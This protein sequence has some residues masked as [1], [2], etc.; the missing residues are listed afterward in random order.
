MEFLSCAGLVVL[1]VLFMYTYQVLSS[2]LAHV[3]GPWYNSWT[4]A[5]YKYHL[6]TG[7]APKYVQSLHEKYGP[8]VRISPDEVDISDPSAA[9]IIHRI[10]NEF[11]KSPSFYGRLVPGV[12]NIFNTTDLDFHR[13]HRRLLSSPISESSLRTNFMPIVDAKVRLAIERIAGEAEKRGAADVFKWWLFM[14]ADIISQLSFGNSFNMLENGKKTQYIL[15]I[16]AT[17]PAAGIRLTFPALYYLA[18]YIHI[19]VLKDAVKTQ[20]RMFQYAQQ[21]ILNHKKL[22]DDGSPEARQTLFTKLYRAGEEGLS[23]LEI[24]CDAQAY[25]VAGSDTAAI[26]LSYLI[27]A[28]CRHSKVKQRLVRELQTLPA[29]F[30][31]MEIRNLRYLHLVV[32]EALRLYCAAPAGLPRVVPPGGAELAGYRLPAGI[33]VRTQAY[34]LHREPTVFHEPERFI[35]ERWE[36]PTREMKDAFMPFGGGSRTCIGLHLARLELRLATAIFFHRFP[37]AE[38]SCLEGMTDEDMVPKMFFLLQPK[39]KRCLIQVI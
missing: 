20:K 19:P 31:D 4:S 37:S 9:Q 8:V 17:G 15:D 5:I 10:K 11:P 3:P 39:G 30:G 12:E 27:W 28:V 25:I 1:V 14:A 36:H 22:T 24:T 7:C 18:Q 35:P 26:T 13:R 38:V 2:P 21:S 33:V 6:L 16:E 32:E 29:G 23:S 34:S